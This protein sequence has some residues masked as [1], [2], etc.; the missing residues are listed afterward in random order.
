[1]W[2]DS[3][4]ADFTSTAL[5]Q[6]LVRAAGGVG[7]NTASPGAELEVNGYDTSLRLRNWND[8]VGGFAGNTWASLQF[9]L[10][11]PGSSAVDA[12]PAGRERSFFGMDSVGRVGSMTNVFGQPAYRNLLDDGAGRL[13]VDQLNANAGSIGGAALTFGRD[14]GE[15][16]ASRRRA[17]TNQWGLDLFTWFRPRLSIAQ[18]GYVGIGTNAP[19]APFDIALGDKRL[20]IRHDAGLVPGINLTG[21]NGN[22]GVMRLRN[23][24]EVWPSDDT[25]RAAKVD[26]RDRNGN[27]TISLNGSGLAT[28][29]VLEITGGADVAEPFPLSEDDIP[30]GSVVVIDENAPGRLKRSDRAYDTR[31]AGIVSGANGVRPGLSLRQQG[32]LDGGKHVALSGRVY[33]LADAGDTPIRPGDLLTTSITPGHAM[34]ATDAARARGAVLGKAMSAL[35]AGRGPVLVLVTL[36]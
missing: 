7:V 22:V 27:P 12:V 35:P 3:Q 17:G 25:N 21:V 10:Y 29:K 6:F 30:E 2:A 33:A 9:G 15:G 14:S 23:S 19:Q 32:A 11:N 24:L 28:V 34:K 20:Q 13:V 16:I 1:V 5:N 31:V 18:N 4:N 26:V 36:Q 8:S